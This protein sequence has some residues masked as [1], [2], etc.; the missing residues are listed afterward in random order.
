MTPSKR[1][2]SKTNDMSVETEHTCPAVSRN[3]PKRKSDRRILRTRDRLGDALVKLILEE[4]FETIT[5]QDILDQAGISR[6]T[7]YSH[8]SDKNDLFVSD[9][10]AFLEGMSTLLSREQEVSERI[11]PVRELFAHIAEGRKLYAALVEAGML[12]VFLE[13]A[14]GHLAR[15]IEQRL[16][17]LAAFRRRPKQRSP[18]AHAFAGALLSLLS[19][20]INRNM[21]NSPGEMDDLYHGIVWS[22]MTLERPRSDVISK[23]TPS[24]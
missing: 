15:G 16:I 4:P 14:R 19:W 11:A 3:A 22:G 5:V 23:K 8:Y 18:A 13:L 1:R 17:D 12:H 6:S 2:S 7:F 24:K 9:M 10:D 20:W 21:P